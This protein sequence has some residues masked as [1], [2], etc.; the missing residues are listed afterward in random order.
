MVVVVVA[1]AAAAAVAAVAVVVEERVAVLVVVVVFLVSKLHGMLKEAKLRAS[2]CSF[3]FPA[4]KSFKCS[5]FS[6]I[7]LPHIDMLAYR[8]PRKGPAGSPC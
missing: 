1:A 7:L 6:Q 2:G 3:F 4:S 8:P 5:V